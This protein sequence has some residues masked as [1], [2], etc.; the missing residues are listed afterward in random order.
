MDLINQI[1]LDHIKRKHLEEPLPITIFDPNQPIS[2]ITT[3]SNTPFVHFQIFTYFLSHCTLTS[4][5]IVNNQTQLLTFC[6]DQ[7]RDN[8]NQL[9]ILEEFEQTYSSTNAFW[10]YTLD[11]FLYQLLTKSLIE[12]DIQ[13]IGILRF[14]MVDLHRQLKQNQ[15]KKNQRFYR[16][17]L[18]TDDELDFFKGS[19]GKYLS[20]NRFFSTYHDRE[21]AVDF[22]RD[23]STLYH[24]VLLKFDHKSRLDSNQP[25]ANLTFLGQTNEETLFSFGCLFRLEN[26]QHHRKDHLIVIHLTLAHRDHRHF[27]SIFDYIEQQFGENECNFLSLGNALRRIDKLD[28]AQKCYEHVLKD[29]HSN[30]ECIA[31]AYHHLGR[32]AASKG[33][34]EISLDYLNHSLNLKLKL[35]KSTDTRL[36][37]SYN[38]IGIVYQ[39]QGEQ[40]KALEAFNK[41]LLIWKRINGKNHLTVAGCYNNMGVAYKRAKKYLQALECFEKALAIRQGNSTTDP[42]D[43]AGSHNNLG[44][45]YERLGHHDLSIEHYNLSLKIKSKSLPAQHPSIASTLEN[46]GYVYENRGAFIQALSYLEKA[47]I[48]YRQSLPSNHHDVQQIEQSLERVSSKL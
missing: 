44:A 43:L 15:T 13:L 47:A 29:V 23:S 38:S 40:D 10:W 28:Q 21:Y 35:F 42:Y 39:K 7:Y 18:M 16:G 24:R 6:K 11:S 12:M 4:E 36:A 9:K 22:L 20:I 41:A 45:V 19:I 5:E 30:D 33:D 34:Y 8:P 25:F 1:K 32:M 2:S 37:Q 46:L 31:R 14:F 48:I 26:I 17:Y 27:H 3:N